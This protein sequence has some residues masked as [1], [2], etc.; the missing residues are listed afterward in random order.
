[1]RNTGI[2]VTCCAL[3]ILKVICEELLQLSHGLVVDAGFTHFLFV[4][5]ASKDIIYLTE[6]LRRSLI[7]TSER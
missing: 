1:M 4:F 6:I 2:K 5:L 7:D 3:I